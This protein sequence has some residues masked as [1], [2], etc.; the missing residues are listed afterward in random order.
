MK[1]AVLLCLA[2]L[3]R[4]SAQTPSQPIAG[5]V[6][7]RD[8]NLLSVPGVLGNLLPGVSVPLASDPVLSAAFTSTGGAI[9]TGS[10]MLTVNGSGAILSRMATPSGPAIWGL[11]ADGSLQWMY[12]AG[13]TQIVN[14]TG[15]SPIEATSLGDELIALGTAGSVGLPVLIRTGTQLWTEIV[16][17]AGG[18]VSQQSPITGSAPAIAFEG[19]WLVTGTNGLI[20]IGAAG[21]TPLEIASPAPILSLQTAGPHSVAVNG[22]WLLNR[23]W[24]LLEIP[25]TVITRPRSVI[26]PPRIDRP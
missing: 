9:K 1:L 18:A 22:Q 8:G 19:G 2:S 15:G 14:L 21:Q 5:M 17:P 20:W 23:S 12:V 4:V 25:G 3:L 24:S 13:S 7:N 11:A 16:N 26:S 10:E 6:L